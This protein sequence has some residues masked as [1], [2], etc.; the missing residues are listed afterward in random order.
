MHG[1][2]R[3]PTNERVERRGWWAR[4]QSKSERTCIT[5]NYDPQAM[6]DYQRGSLNSTSGMQVYEVPVRAV[7]YVP[8][9]SIIT[10][11]SMLVSMVRERVSQGDVTAP[12]AMLSEPEAGFT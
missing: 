1:E 11:L 6:R 3:S 10:S 5:Q 7:P 9:A 2:G 4:G 8:D 12:Q